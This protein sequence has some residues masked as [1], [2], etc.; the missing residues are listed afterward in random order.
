[1]GKS[2][3]TVRR[4]IRDGKLAAH[5]EKIDPWGP[6][7]VINEGDLQRLITPDH[8]LV[9]LLRDDS[10]SP[11]QFAQGVREGLMTLH[12]LIMGLDQG[13][14]QALDDHRTQVETLLTTQDEALRSELTA[15]HIEIAQLRA[16]LAKP[17]RTPFWHRVFHRDG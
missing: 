14:T 11:S 12:T 2:E 3:V 4:M 7:W 6:T 17:T 16:Q 5:L 15:L 13:V 10:S 8:P 1:M 9:E